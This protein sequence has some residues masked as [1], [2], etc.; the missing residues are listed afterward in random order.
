MEKREYKSHL[1]RNMYATI[2]HNSVC[3]DLRVITTRMSLNEA[4]YLNIGSTISIINKK[5]MSADVK[6][7]YFQQSLKVLQT[8]MLKDM[9][10][11]ELLGQGK[12]ELETN[13][14]EEVNYHYTTEEA[15]RAMRDTEE[16]EHGETS[17]LKRGSTVKLE[18]T[19]TKKMR[20]VEAEI[21]IT[22]DSDE[23]A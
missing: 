15:L 21:L 4:E 9:R 11:N 17:S 10:F 1:G 6:I 16:T 20:A 5:L 23:D 12:Q 19:M 8:Q 3:V 14:I 2:G 22:V 7:K 13:Q 18:C